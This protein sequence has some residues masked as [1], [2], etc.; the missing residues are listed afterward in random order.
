M[1]GIGEGQLERQWEWGQGQNARV[2][3]DLCLVRPELEQGLGEQAALDGRRERVAVLLDFAL[4]AELALEPVQVVG[5][6]RGCLGSLGQDG[7]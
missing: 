4:V 3:D 7:R 2:D 6:R 5:R 1:V